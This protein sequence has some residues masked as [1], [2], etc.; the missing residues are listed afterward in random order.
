M[1]DDRRPS[2]LVVKRNLSARFRCA[3]AAADNF[4][5]VLNTRQKFHL[6]RN[7]KEEREWFYSGKFAF[8]NFSP[9]FPFTDKKKDRSRAGRKIGQTISPY[10]KEIVQ[11]EYKK[12]AWAFHLKSFA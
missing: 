3:Y 4:H 6:K 9:A 2:G 8:W 10:S 12:G 11:R 1:A 5:G 7:R